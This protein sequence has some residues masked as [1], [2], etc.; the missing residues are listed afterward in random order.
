M[1]N[2]KLVISGQ[3]P[4]QKNQKKMA[5][6]GGRMI[7]YT[8]AQV[9]DW[10]QSASWELKG[11][12]QFKGKVIIDYIFYVKDNRR[13]DLDNMLC[14]VNDALVKAGIIED[15]T[16]QVLEIGSVIGELDKSNPRAEVFIEEAGEAIP[17][18]AEGKKT[19]DKG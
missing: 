6:I 5:N 16:W 1:V 18:V 15:D 2:T 10:Q 11:K 13:R 12:P 4:A 19:V 3:V 8:S 9:K 7:L 17:T 14:T